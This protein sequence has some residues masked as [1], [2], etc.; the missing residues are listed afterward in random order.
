[1]KKDVRKNGKRR[2][3]LDLFLLLMLFLCLA[4]GVLQWLDIRNAEGIDREQGVLL[5][6]YSDGISAMTAECLRIGEAL[7]QA[8]GSCF[9]TLERIERLPLRASL[10]H[11]GKEFFGTWELEQKCRLRITVSASGSM[12]RGSFLYK[13]KTPL[14][15][16]EAIVL[17]SRGSELEYRLSRCRPSA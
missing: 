17:R 16:G 12:H 13:G 14:G 4:S 3:V 10:M 11:D 9:G 7:Y 5:E 15:I 2:T 8:D 6:F 1:M